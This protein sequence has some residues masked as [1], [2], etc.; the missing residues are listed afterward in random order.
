MTDIR[1]SYDRTVCY[2]LQ[3]ALSPGETYALQEHDIEARRTPASDLPAEATR[4][5]IVHSHE[6][7]DENAA[8]TRKE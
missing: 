2:P 6:G 4:R 5:S 3:R 8:K 7:H 1:P